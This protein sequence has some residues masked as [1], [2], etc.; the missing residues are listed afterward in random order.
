MGRYMRCMFQ[1]SP[2]KNSTV[3]HR[4][5]CALQIHNLANYCEGVPLDVILQ[6][7]LPGFESS[8]EMA[9]LQRF[10]ARLSSF[11]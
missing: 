8:T 9:G 3:H 1:T 5:P 10:V 11:F 7:V 6:D 2:M 4:L